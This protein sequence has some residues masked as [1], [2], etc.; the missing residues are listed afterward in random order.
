MA[1][2]VDRSSQESALC[3]CCG[4]SRGEGRSHRRFCSGSCRA[5][6]SRLRRERQ[7]DVLIDSVEQMIAAVRAS[8]RART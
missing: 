5:K 2:D 6:A 3:A 8:R 1:A 4:R 7:I